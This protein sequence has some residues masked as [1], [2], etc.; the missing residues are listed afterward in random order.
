M[1]RVLKMVIEE[2][3][4]VDITAPQCP[5]HQ[6]DSMFVLSYCTHKKCLHKD[7]DG[8]FHAR[9]LPPQPAKPPRWCP[10]PKK[11]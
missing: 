1:S 11:G 6:E 10:L 8:E 4:P 5:F 2:C 9:K 3:C 7:E